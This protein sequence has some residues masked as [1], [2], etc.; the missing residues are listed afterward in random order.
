MLL[1]YT[2]L[3]RYFSVFMIALMSPTVSNLSSDVSTALSHRAEKSPSS[4]FQAYAVERSML[5]ASAASPGAIPAASCSMNSSLFAAVATSVRG[6]CS[7][8]ADL[9]ASFP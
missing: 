5:I 7:C 9:Y 4:F 3:R 8:P 2:C 6:A 1:L